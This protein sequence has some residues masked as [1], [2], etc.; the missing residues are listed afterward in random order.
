MSSKRTILT[1]LLLLALISTIYSFQPELTRDPAEAR[2]I[3][4]QAYIFAYPMLENYRTM[5]T[6]VL[7][8]GGFNRFTHFNRLHGP[9]NRLIVRPNNDTIYSMIWLELSTEPIVISIPEITDRY[10][11][12]QLVDMYTHNLAYV[13]TRATG[14]D[15]KTVMIVSPCWEGET[16]PG[17][18]E[19]FYSEGNYVYCIVRT[20]VDSELPGDLQRVLEIQQQYLL[21]P[22]SNYYGTPALEELH[23]V[24]LPPFDQTVA[25]S[26]G[27]I[28]Y[29][30]FLLGQLKIHPSEEALIQSFSKIGIGPDY[31]F[32]PDN[33]TEPVLEAIESAIAEARDEISA[34][35]KEIGIVKDGWSLSERIFGSRER[36]HGLY[37][38]RATAAHIGLY[39]NDLEETFYPNCLYDSDGEPLDA[40]RYNY[41]INFAKE[42]L[43]PVDPKGFWS[44]TMYDEE[45]FLV[46]NPLN[47]YS[48]GDRSELTYGEDG[49][50]VL[51]LQHESPGESKESNWLPAPDGKFKITMR[52]YIPLPEGL[53]PLYCPPAVRKAGVVE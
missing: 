10:Y 16:P 9:Q 52:I 28:G 45:Q 43:P 47:R 5:S 12:F 8:F 39:G 29:F 14:S 49:S 37:L 46:D 30:N 7:Q 19:V 13:G 11:S 35:E 36:M 15:A 50:L 18:D 22:L 21:Q 41:V 4:R 26:A 31:P 53:D 48:I 42:Q 1:C 40:S 38:I 27:F 23:A 44:I 6:Q 34:M 20:G 2:A 51:Y 17:I 25:D 32:D 33:L 24:K 3:A